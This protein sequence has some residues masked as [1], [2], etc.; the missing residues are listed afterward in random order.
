[1]FVAVDSEEGQSFGPFN[2][3][4]EGVRWV[5]KRLLDTGIIRY[6]DEAEALKWPDGDDIRQIQQDLM[7]C[8]WFVFE[9]EFVEPEPEPEISWCGHVW[10]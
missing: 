3:N 10:A 6:A 8:G 2:T 4:D 5:H 7:D 9:V 1:M